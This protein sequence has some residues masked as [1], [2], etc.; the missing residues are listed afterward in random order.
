MLFKQSIFVKDPKKKKEYEDSRI[1]IYSLYL[2][3]ID[4]SIYSIFKG[5]LY[6][7]F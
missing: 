7:Q 1:A 6:V 3:G 5:E 2:T 4:I